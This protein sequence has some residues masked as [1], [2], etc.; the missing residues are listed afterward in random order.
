M[1]NQPTLLTD[2]ASKL[3]FAGHAVG[4]NFCGADA[5]TGAGCDEDPNLSGTDKNQ[6]KWHR[7]IRSRGQIENVTLTAQFLTIKAETR[8]DN[9]GG[10]FVV[11]LYHVS[12]AVT[13]P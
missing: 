1:T 4:S 13:M 11:S 7:R 5:V 2:A 6:R 10:R 8:T 3:A 9:S 12:I